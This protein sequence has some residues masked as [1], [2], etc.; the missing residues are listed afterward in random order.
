MMEPIY[1]DQDAT[2][3]LRAEVLE[4]MLPY[5]KGEF[6]NASSIHGFGRSAATSINE[7]REKGPGPRRALLRSEPGGGQW[8]SRAAS[9]AW[10]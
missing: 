3:P 4:A 10:N 2:T 5:L 7:G 9:P 8:R 6:G 1:M